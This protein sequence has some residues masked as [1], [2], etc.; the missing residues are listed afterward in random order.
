MP[1]NKQSSIHIPGCGDLKI[2]D[3]SFLPDPCPLPEQ[4]KKRALV[5]RERLIYAPFSGVGGIVYDKD[6]VYVELGGSHSHTK[7]DTGLMGQLLQQTQETLDHKLKRSE[8]QFFTDSVPIKSQ[9]VKEIFGEEQV[10]DE[11]RIRRKVVFNDSS[12]GKDD[13]DDDDESEAEMDVDDGE[14]DEDAL[15]DELKKMGDDSGEDSDEGSEDEGEEENDEED[16]EKLVTEVGC[17]VGKG[18]KR[19]LL[20]K[21][22]GKRVKLDPSMPAEGESTPVYRELRIN[23]DKHVKDKISE[24]LSLLSS[25][26]PKE[27]KADETSLQATESKSQDDDESFDELS[28]DE[29]ADFE[30]KLDNESEEDED[31][32]E[33]DNMK[34]KT[35]IAQRAR[36]AFQN[37]QQSNVNPTKLV[38][39]VFDKN[40]D[41]RDD[42]DEEAEEEAGDSVGGIFRVVQEKQREK[43]RER[44]LKN[45]EESAFFS[46]ELPRDWLDDDNKALLVNRFVTG[47]W[48]ESEDAEELLKLGNV[49]FFWILDFDLGEIQKGI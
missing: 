21:S 38:Y 42:E 41:P 28:E 48:K 40:R 27:S 3:I 26:S 18:R 13:D 29:D 34:W 37:R 17:E 5:E 19:K 49:F 2:K 43:L 47:Q 20:D 25:K 9:D 35:N 44:E 24:A 31:E 39:G 46:K 14:M 4:L 36:E 1:F 22:G 16:E 11:G 23:Q 10:R 33:E 6:A 8:L 12:G 7:D 15:K 30:L 45:Q 32:N